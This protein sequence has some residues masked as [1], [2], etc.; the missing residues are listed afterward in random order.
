MA[1]LTIDLT[2]AGGLLERHQGDLNDTAAKPYLRYLGQDDG[3]ADGIFNP[4]KLYGY[5]S[6][7][8]STYTTLTGTI[9]APINQIVYNPKDDEVY[10][11]EQGENILYLDG[12]N[13]TSL[14]N[15]LTVT[16]SGD[17]IKD[18]E[19]YEINGSRALFYLLDS[20]DPAYR[21]DG[22]TLNST[23]PDE[24]FGGVGGQYVGFK[25]LDTPVNDSDYVIEADEDTIYSWGSTQYRT[26]T[27][28][29]G[30]NY[31]TKLSQPFST[32]LITTNTIQSIGLRLI[33]VL[34]SGSGVTLKLS[35]QT[36]ADRNTAPYTYQGTWATST[37]YSVGDTVTQSS[38]DYVC[39]QAHTSGASS[40]PG[41]GGANEDYWNRFGAPSGTEVASAT[42]SGDDVPDATT[43][44]VPGFSGRTDTNV[45]TLN[46]VY[47]NFSSDVTLSANTI[48]WLVLEESG[49]NMTS[50]TAV[51]WSN[52]NNNEATYSTGTAGD[53]SKH[54]GTNPVGPWASNYWVNDNPNAEDNI[55]SR[56]F[57]FVFTRFDYWS[58][59]MAAGHFIVQPGENGWLHRSDDG[60]LYWVQDRTL[61]R[62]D[63]RSTG[64]P[65]GRTNPNIF[66]FPEHI[67]ISDI[68]ETRGQMYF[69][70]QT[71]DYTT[72]TQ[73]RT[74]PSASAG[75]VIWNRRALVVGSTD[76]Y[77][78]PGAREIKSVFPFATGDVRIIT[79]NDAGF[80][81]I[82]Q[83][84][85]NQYEVVQTFEKDGFPVNRKGIKNLAGMAFWTGLNGIHY[86]YGRVY[87]QA[88]IRLYK[89]GNIIDEAN[90]GFIPGPLLVGHEES[91]EPRQG[92]FQAWQDGDPSY[93][94]QKWYP[95]GD[96][97]I[98]SIAQKANAG[99]VYSK[100]FLFGGKVKI[101]YAQLFLR[102]TTS[103]GSTQIA[104]VKVYFNQSSTASH[105]FNITQKDA[106]DGFMYLP[107]GKRNTPHAIQVEVEFD[108][109]QTLGDDDFNPA[110]LE[111]DYDFVD[112]KK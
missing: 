97:T 22:G 92:I 2:G 38:V 59:D 23:V 54:Y 16:N 82:R 104:T 80:C 3:Y 89:I 61:H 86:A 25:L 39:L 78:A 40:Q 34:G 67:T 43:S 87:P 24:Y 6:P 50:S 4:F 91:S 74:F 33:W 52:T 110:F 62:L 64:G 42:V 99:N 72:T 112:K 46:R 14:V 48:Y 73:D 71:A 47:F 8:V 44:N 94:V 32:D 36:E 75:V 83:L 13:D 58:R 101:N 65:T 26:S 19:L 108:E 98:D 53:S 55:E 29:D 95:N 70:I 49:S 30:T 90:S 60:Y 35:I 68:G 77:N 106:S 27:I 111:L 9:A 12:L 109:T 17:T 107:I 51:T 63:G 69:G 41:I 7:A 56:D 20:G 28:D 21:I 57:R 81:E 103:S 18:M 1:K 10:F 105:T 88:P 76:Y 100:V 85:G 37:S 5:M 15:Y 45:A 93:I 31:S 102:P 66:T 11:S 96:G 79:T 84:S